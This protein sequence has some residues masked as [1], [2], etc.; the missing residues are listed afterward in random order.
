MY[1]KNSRIDK[2]PMF[3]WNKDKYPYMLDHN[4]YEFFN[5]KLPQYIEDISWPFF[6]NLLGRSY[7]TVICK[8]NIDYIDDYAKSQG[9]QLLGNNL[10]IDGYV[11]YPKNDLCNFFEGIS[12]TSKGTKLY[13][14]YNEAQNDNLLENESNVIVH[15]KSSVSY[16]VRRI[17]KKDDDY[18]IFDD[19][20]IMLLSLKNVKL[21]KEQIKHICE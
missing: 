8:R 2:K 18:R 1:G 7:L 10:D 14:N 11:L 12:K 6:G 5:G 21:T 19:I 3:K 20:P 16:K 4:I 17:Y 9:Y 15:I 13:F